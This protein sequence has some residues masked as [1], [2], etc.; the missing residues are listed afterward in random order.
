MADNT[1][2]VAAPVSADDVFATRPRVYIS[3]TDPKTQDI[4]KPVSADDVYSKFNQFKTEAAATPRP[5]DRSFVQKIGE[6]FRR[7]AISS[8]NNRLGAM[9]LTSQQPDKNDYVD[10]AY[11]GAEING[12]EKDSTFYKQD[13]EGNFAPVDHDKHLVFKD[14]DDEKFKIYNRDPSKN[15]SH[16][17]GA[18]VGMGQ[19]VQEGFNAG[20][21]TRLPSLAG[22]A[23]RGQEALRAAGGVRDT[24]GVHVPVPQNMVTEN[25]VSPIIAHTAEAIPGGGA[26]FEQAA[27]GLEHGVE[28]AA[29]RASTMNTGGV[30]HTA[31]SAGESAR[32]AI[33]DYA[34]PKT[35]ILAQRVSKAYDA[36]DAHV[37]GDV[38][39]DLKNTRAVAQDIQTRYEGTG[40][41]GLSPTIKKV[42]GAVT[43]PK[44]ITY[45]G[46]KDLRSEI[47]EM[48]ESGTK[49]SE[50][51]VS[52]KQLRGLY[53]G[54]SDDMRDLVAAQ[55]GPEGSKLW[56]RANKLAA[57]ASKR[58]EELGKTL[59]TN[60][61]DEGIFGAIMNKAGSANSA[62]AKTLATAKKSMPADEWNE[63]ASAVV[64]RLGKTR[65]TAGENF[66][67]GKFVTDYSKLSDRGKSILFGDNQRLRKALDN[68]SDLAKFNE[69]VRH[70]G[71][72]A[73]LL[74]AG[75]VLSHAG[76]G[77]GVIG[78]LGGA[79]HIAAAMLGVRKIGQMLSKPATAESVAKWMQGYKLATLKPTK[80]NVMLFSKASDL[81]ANDASKEDRENIRTVAS[82]A[83]G[84]AKKL[85][86]AVSPFGKTQ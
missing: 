16:L 10:K 38:P 77:E 64:G 18:L 30:A 59:G 28:T 46:V 78:K 52:D 68:I 61:S 75:T 65:T 3:R 5:E 43:D 50:T 13:E 73:H 63:I 47:G 41:E 17:T 81:L 84:L 45:Q 12:D 67:V 55:G 76:G 51:G 25:A 37:P 44:G 4:P 20:A 14:P 9:Q 26:P 48:L 7:G 49:I 11:T 29:S 33:E 32:G 19:V 69:P 27:A 72:I 6:N 36:V 39:H 22:T 79:L 31:E 86:S 62:D 83:G 34:A 35:G 56:N 85:V 71:P 40:Q 24:T 57:A 66:D 74:G 42:L 60:R 2:S 15:Y 54:L 80:G 21:P 53:K 58:R 23:T 1:Q 8:E 70:P 82:D